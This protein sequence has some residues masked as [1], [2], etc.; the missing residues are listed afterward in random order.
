VKKTNFDRYLDKQ[1]K[2]PE[3]VARFERTGHE[4]KVT[5]QLTALR[6]QTGL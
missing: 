2:D 5:L 3:F 1:L 4:W 6:Q